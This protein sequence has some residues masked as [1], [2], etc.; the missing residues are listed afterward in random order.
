MNLCAIIEK[1]YGWTEYLYKCPVCGGFEKIRNK[2]DTSHEIKLEISC[3]NCE[4]R[5]EHELEMLYTRDFSSV[6]L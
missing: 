4:S 6:V 2:K 5:T 3:D 1:P